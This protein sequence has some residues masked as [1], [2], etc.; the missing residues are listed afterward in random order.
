MSFSAN[1]R[2]A[3]ALASVVVMPSCVNS[4]AAC[5]ASSNRSCAGPDPSRGPFLGRGTTSLLLQSEPELVE[6]ALH[7]VDRLLPEVA[8]VHQLGLALLDE[9]ADRVDALA[10]QAVVGAHREVELLHRDGKI[11]RLLLV[12]L[13]RPARQAGGL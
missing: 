12:V 13:A 6:L 4:D 2:S 7:L 3:L 1:G 9:V 10:L 11:T 5:P 8:D